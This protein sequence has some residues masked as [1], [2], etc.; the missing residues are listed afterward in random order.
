[1]S[2]VIAIPQLITQAATDLAAIDAS[3]KAAHLTTAA[4]T[5]A[6]L[7]AAADEV[8]E[9]IA[10]LFSGYGRQYQQVADTA[11]AYQ[12]QFVGHLT[13][14]AGAYAGAEAVNAALLLPASAGA[15][16]AAI[17]SLDQIGDA[18]IQL[19]FDILAGVYYLGFFLLIPIYG[20]LAL[21]LPFAFLGSLFPGFALAF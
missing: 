11:A 4:P 19:F 12:Q 16:A 2:A 8:S 3:L 6:L 18:L 5:Q 7:P 10:Q 14:A 17:P 1:M 21:Y 13:S 15:I 20:A 9:G